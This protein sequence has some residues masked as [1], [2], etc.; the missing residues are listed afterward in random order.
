VLP[1]GASATLPVTITPRAARGTVVAG[2]LF[3]DTGNPV[4]SSGSE[5]AMLPYRYTVG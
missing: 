2:R 5:L 4:T 3:V 1:P